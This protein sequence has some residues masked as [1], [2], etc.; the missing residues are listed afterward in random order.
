MN[1]KLI[2]FTGTSI[3]F[4]VELLFIEF[5]KNTNLYYF[6]MIFLSLSIVNFTCEFLTTT[7]LKHLPT[8]VVLSKGFQLV[9]RVPV[10]DK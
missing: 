4:V 2:N 3:Y 5:D 6:M 7:H 1:I 9:N 10:V 8:L